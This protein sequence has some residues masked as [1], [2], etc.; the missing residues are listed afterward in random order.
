MCKKTEIEKT[1]RSTPIILF[2]S[3]LHS[4]LDLRIEGIVTGL[5]PGS[6]QVQVFGIVNPVRYSGPGKPRICS[7]GLP[8]LRPSLP[9]SDV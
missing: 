1:F 6:E 7:R 8:D 3:E 4:M 9:D 2:L 5:F